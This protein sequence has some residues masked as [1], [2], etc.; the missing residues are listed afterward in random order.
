MTSISTTYLCLF[1]PNWK[2][3]MKSVWFNVPALLWTFYTI[4]IHILNNL[5]GKLSI[6]CVLF[7]SPPPPPPPPPPV[8]LVLYMY[9]FY[10]RLWIK[11]DIIII[12]ITVWVMLS[13]NLQ[14][15]RQTD[16][17][18]NCT[19]SITSFCLG[20]NNLWCTCRDNKKN[21]GITQ[22]VEYSAMCEL[23]LVTRIKVNL[24]TLIYKTVD[25]CWFL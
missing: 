2:I 19:K 21:C 12:I 17:Q 22:I 4:M 6:I 25:I 15:D 18:T 10:T 24:T 7:N 9:M 23:S 16:R 13:T 11:N 14:T 20:G 8:R 3:M 1:F 5:Y